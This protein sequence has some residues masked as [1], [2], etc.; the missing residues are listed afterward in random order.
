MTG[1]WADELALG[2]PAAR[3]LPGDGLQISKGGEQMKIK[4]NLK[5]G[6]KADRIQ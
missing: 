3:V 4:S 6:M 2:G 5:V 1:T